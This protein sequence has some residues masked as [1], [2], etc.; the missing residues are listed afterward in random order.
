MRIHKRTQEG[1]NLV[2]KTKENNKCL[3]QIIT[4]FSFSHEQIKIQ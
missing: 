3:N 4:V 1:K 2:I